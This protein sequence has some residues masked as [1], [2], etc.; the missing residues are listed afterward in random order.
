MDGKYTFSG[1]GERELLDDRQVLEIFSF[2]Y[3][4]NDG[5]ISR[6]CAEVAS[7]LAANR[8]NVRVLTQS[9]TKTG[10][11]IPNL[12]EHRVAASRPSRELAAWWYLLRHR[13]VEPVIAGTWYPE[14]L[15]AM[16][17]CRRRLVI[18]AHGGELMP[19]PQRW[20]R[21]AWAWL[22]QR[23]L[24][25]ADLVIANSAFTAQLVAW[26]APRSSVRAIPLAVDHERFCPGDRQAAR[27][28]FGVTDPALRI[29]SSVSRICDYKGHHTVFDALA[30]LDPSIRR[31]IVYLIAGRG[32][33]LARL[34]QD[35]ARLGI[36]NVVRWLG[37]VSEDNLPELYR[38]SDLFVLCTRESRAAQ[39]VE[40]FGLV[41]L[42]A[43]AC[44]TPVVGTRTGGIPDA[45]HGGDGGWLIAQGD[46]AALARI[47]SA[48]VTDPSIFRAEGAAGRV[49]IERA[50][51]WDHYVRQFSTA[52]VEGDLLRG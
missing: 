51:T 1:D 35:A 22:Q 48:L 8:S 6:L 5:G 20:R 11:N 36:D 26:A 2:D 13:R 52:L 30:A 40:G 18:L 9:L 27:A 15:I 33:D 31:Q 28:A 39:E 32:P 46:V 45:I 3:P 34:Q 50:C 17:A 42:E 19:P 7:G 47:L 12:P 4:P 29:I 37:Y 14:G 44:G 21:F 38:A 10:N 16:L 41:F 43:Q 25:R 23:V 24:S 49:R